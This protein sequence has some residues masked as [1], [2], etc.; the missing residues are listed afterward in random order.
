MLVTSSN[1]HPSSFLLLV[2]MLG[3]TSSFL[4]LVARPFV[5]STHKFGWPS[6]DGTKWHRC[7]PIHS[8][9]FI[10]TPIQSAGAMDLNTDNPMVELVHSKLPQVTLERGELFPLLFLAAQGELLSTLTTSGPHD[11]SLGSSI[12]S[13]PEKL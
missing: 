13:F 5:T 8:R 10:W 4:L 6:F 9:W 7:P 1:G 3:A 2:V 11:K 12:G